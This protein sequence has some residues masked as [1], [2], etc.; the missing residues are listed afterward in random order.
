ME[1]K[2]N[3]NIQ[4]INCAHYLDYFLPIC[5]E[6]NSKIAI[7]KLDLINIHELSH[8]M[9]TSQIFTFDSL[10]QSMLWGK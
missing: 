2:Y 3:G 6:Q 5:I 4:E 10:V 8:V 7:F 9:M 1:Q